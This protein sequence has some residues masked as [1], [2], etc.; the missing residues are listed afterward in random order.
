MKTMPHICTI[1]K[2]NS[3]SCLPLLQ[4]PNWWQRT[5]RNLRKHI[6]VSDRDPRIIEYYRTTTGLMNEKR[7]QV[8]SSH[9][10]MIHPFSDFTNV[11]EAV[12]TL[13]FLICFILIPFIDAYKREH[14]LHLSSQNILLSLA[15]I[16]CILDIILRFFTGYVEDKLKIA[17]LDQGKV[18]RHYILG[19]Y[20]V[21]DVISSLPTDIVGYIYP[22]SKVIYTAHF[23]RL[24][25]LIRFSTFLKNFEKTT[26]FIRW[27]N[28]ILRSVQYMLVVIIVVHWITCANFFVPHIRS[29]L[30]GETHQFSWTLKLED[31]HEMKQYLLTFFRTAGLLLCALSYQP[32]NFAE[33]AKMVEESTTPIPKKLPSEIEP[34]V[35]ISE[36][37]IS[38]LFSSP[39]EEVLMD[40]IT[41]ILGK[42]LTCAFAGE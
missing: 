22:Q 6:L 27:N 23:L 26:F 32:D 7:R 16:F 8:E 41:I 12:M 39:F 38:A 24:F 3:G 4:H 20:F 2:P 9:Y 15:N 29:M 18:A 11:H 17:I 40:L 30:T 13:V 25:K 1:E 31:E 14:I 35:E 10:Y 33:V 34:F 37:Y 5:S 21:C 19:P 42:I 28:T 36:I